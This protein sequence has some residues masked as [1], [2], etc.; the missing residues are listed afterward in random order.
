MRQ[1]RPITP[2][3]VERLSPDIASE[4]VTDAIVE[5]EMAKRYHAI[6]AAAGARNGS[7]NDR[8][9]RAHGPNERLRI[10]AA[11]EADEVRMG[12]R[13][14]AIAEGGQPVQAI[15]TREVNQWPEVAGLGVFDARAFVTLPERHAVPSE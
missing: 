4:F 8:W 10:A 6:G 2:L 13:R 5:H 11:I 15:A 1:R 9:L 12:W 14:A 3:F 7:A